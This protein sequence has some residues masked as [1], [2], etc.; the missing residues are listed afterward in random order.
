MQIKAEHIVPCI[1]PYYKT[2]LLVHEGHMQWLFDHTGRRFLDMFSGI[3]T[4]SVGHCHPKVNAAAMEQMKSLWHT[5]NI[6]MHPKMYEYA[7]KLTDKLPGDLKVVYIVNSGSEAN[8][9]AMLLSRVYTKNFDIISFRNAYHGASPYSMGVTALSKWKY[10]VPSNM[11]VH[12]AMNP[13]V[14]KGIWG[15][16]KCRDSPVQAD[17]TCSCAGECSASRHYYKQLQEVFKYSLPRGHVAALIAESIQGIGGVVQFPKGFLKMAYELVRTNGGL[18]VAD[19]VQTG[20][21]RTGDHFW[22]FEMHGVVP[23][24]VTMAKGIGNGFPLAA[25]VTTPKIAAA[26]GTALHFNT[27]GGN[28][29]AC[30]VGLATLQA[31]EEEK[32]QANSKKVGTHLLM[33]LEKLREEFPCVGDVRGKGLMI[34]VELVADKESKEPLAAK[35]FADV[36]E[37]CKDMG[38]L[39][40]RGGTH[41]NVSIPISNTLLTNRA[42]I[43]PE[44]L[45]V[46]YSGCLFQHQAQESILVCFLHTD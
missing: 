26:L 12:H 30:A 3:V 43:C 15:G 40:G 19:E 4:I 45:P 10:H 13:D 21:G 34:G 11:G 5:T 16:S 25:V 44:M 27:F 2:P 6:Y 35:Q 33:E 41:G 32:L 7:E 23:D 29:V 20:F 39:I 37:D 1:Q 22:G 8:D 36:W 18:C 24:I 31:I 28:P 17:R 14:Y 46:R 38:V 42:S 9:L